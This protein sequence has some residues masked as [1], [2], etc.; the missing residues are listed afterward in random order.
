MRGWLRRRKSDSTADPEVPTAS[1][2]PSHRS[3]SVTGGSPLAVFEPICDRVVVLDC[4][5]TGVY[6]T[7]RVVEVAA[8]TLDLAGQVVDEWETLVN[9][10]RDV[11]PTWLHGVTADMVA[12]A[13]TF[14]QI[15]EELAARVHESLVCAHNLPFDV[16]MLTA[17]YEAAGLDV[18][19][20]GVDTL[21]LAGG[22]LAVACERYGVALDGAHRALH[23]ARA[24]AQLLLH[25]AADAAVPTSASIV[26][27]PTS[28]TTTSR[29]RVRPAGSVVIEAPPSKLAAWAARLDHSGASAALQSYLDVLDRAMADLHLDAQEIAE[30]A[31]LASGL[32]LSA[33][34]MVTAHR[35]WLDDLIDAACADGVVDEGEYDE[36]L[37]AA[38]VLEVPTDR[39]EKRTA[40]RRTTT[41]AVT[42]DLDVGVAFTGVPLDAYGNEIPRGELME[43]AASIGMV[44]EDKFTKSRCGLL[45]A[46]D[47][48]S[49][50][51]KA[52]KA[53]EWGIPIVS[54]AE[55]LA[56]TSGAELTGHVEAVGGMEAATCA[57]CGTAFTRVAKGR[58]QTHCDDCSTEPSGEESKTPA[59]PG[60]EPVVLTTD[61]TTETLSCQV[62]GSPFTREV[63]RGRKPTRCPRCV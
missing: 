54:A 21:A 36:L 26:H 47:P 22:R 33:A 41:R 25:V 58:R 55:F 2:P 12:D 1:S 23:D 45:V 37:R 43:H 49:Q 59:P 31:A 29:R 3:S 62:C 32:G 53:R 17:E 10:C 39:V 50:S 24:C 14:D 61:G 9:P 13:P 34:Q 27:T 16:R 52:A 46:A 4:E 48:S 57:R 35:R 19:L 56:A 44:P 7:D 30:L 11:G 15:A 6:T 20:T 60:M 51:G 28:P 5:T 63:R 38:H 40:T 8:V 18:S 42:A